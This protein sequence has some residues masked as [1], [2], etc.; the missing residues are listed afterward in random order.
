MSNDTRAERKT[1]SLTFA[2]P[3]DTRKPITTTFLV[4]DDEGR[5]ELVIDLTPHEFTSL[6]SGTTLR[7]EPRS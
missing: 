2:K 1:I 4:Q 6:L 7:V 5:V 3:G